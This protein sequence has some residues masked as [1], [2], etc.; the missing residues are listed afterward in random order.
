MKRKFEAWPELVLIDNTYKLLQL[1]YTV[2][3]FG[4]VDGNGC[5]EFIFFAI[6]VHENEEFFIWLINE[7][8]QHHASSCTKV[9]SFMADKDM[10]ARK[11]IKS[12]LNVPVYICA[13]HVQQI[14]RRTITPKNMEISKVQKKECLAHLQRLLYSISESYYNKYYTEFC[15]ESPSKVVD[16]YN[17]NWYGIRQE[18][19]KCY[20]YECNFMN[21]TNNRLESFNQKLKLF[22]DLYSFLTVFLVE[23][24]K[25]IKKIHQHQRSNQAVNIFLKEPL[26]PLTEVERKYF[27][28]LTH[29]ASTYVIN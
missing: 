12:L 24:F 4:I 16:Y 15:N 27:D 13:F 25:F 11:V 6:L 17:S 26:F 14:F 8:K 7:F 3:T 21:M 20:V 29:Y 19:V 28:F 9:K 5:S 1:Q 22:L 10:V 18:W 23:L 2:V